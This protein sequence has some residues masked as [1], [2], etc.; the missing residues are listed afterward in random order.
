[1]QDGKVYWVVEYDDDSASHPNDRGWRRDDRDVYYL[2]AAACQEAVDKKNEQVKTRNITK[3]Q[4]ARVRYDLRRTQW[5]TA[6]DEHSV[7]VAAGL[8]S[9]EYK[10]FGN[11]VPPI[12]EPYLF[13]VGVHHW[14]EKV[15]G[16]KITL[17]VW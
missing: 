11:F 3:H 15:E 2:T 6:R 7:L 5:E 8:R 16:D 9:G 13:R 17:D 14:S 1:M 12:Y 10:T 4:E